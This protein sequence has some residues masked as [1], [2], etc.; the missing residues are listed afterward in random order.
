MPEEINQQKSGESQASAGEKAE[1]EKEKAQESFIDPK[2][3]PEELKPHWKRMH[4]AFSRKMNEIN[5]ANEK[6]EAYDRF[7]SDPEYAK[8]TIRAYAQKYGMSL[9][10]QRAAENYIA[11]AQGGQGNSD[12]PRQLI[13]AVGSKLAPELKWMAESIASAHWEANKL[14][15]APV[16]KRMQDSA[17][18]QAKSEY[19]RMAQELSERA[20]TWEEK[21]DDMTSLLDFIQGEENYHSEFGSKLEILY[22][23]V[24]GNSRATQEAINRISS[25]AKNRGSIGSTG[26]KSSPDLSEKIRGAKNAQDAWKIAADAALKEVS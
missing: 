20:P 15:V 13:E 26:P 1:G 7:M 5:K 24:T 16:I 22:N 3:L 17:K 11:N 25:A 18:K 10:E 4:S 23:I 14:T 6:I 9:V 8:E 19:D 21:E 12:V 2:D